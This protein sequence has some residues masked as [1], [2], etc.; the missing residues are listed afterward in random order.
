MERRLVALFVADAVGYSKRMGED[1]AATIAALSASRSIIDAEINGLGGRIFSTAGDS[2]VAEFSSSADAVNAALNIHAKL[3]QLAPTECFQFRIGIH[4]GDVRVSGD[5]LLGEGLNIAARL[6]PVAP[7]GGICITAT[8]HEQI[9]G[10]IDAGFLPSGR[11]RLKNISHPVE[12]W[13]W[14]ESAVRKRKTR[15]I[16]KLATLA[17]L[18]VCVFGGV[19]IIGWRNMAVVLD[20]PLPSGPKIAVVPF[21]EIGSPENEGFFADGLSRDVNALLS[22][23][24]NLFVLSPASMAQFRGAPDCEKIKDILDVDFILSGTVQRQADKLRVTTEFT[25]AKDCRQ[26]AAPGPFD[27]QLSAAGVLD[28]QLEIARKVVSQIGSS[29]API[30]DNTLIRRIELQAPD[31]LTAYECVLLSYWFYENFAPERHRKARTCLEN[32]VNED[33][34]YSLGWSRLAFSYLESKKYAIDTPPDWAERALEAAQKALS[35]N[36]ENPD[37]YYARAILSQM[38]REDRAVF[39]TN[40]ERAVLLNPND[41]FILA[42]LGTWMAYSGA[43]EKGKG[44]VQRAMLLNPMHQSWWYFIW[45]LHAYDQQQ[46]QASI[47]YSHKVDL[48]NNYMVQSVLTSAYA[49]NGNMQ[50]ARQTLEHVLKLK[51]EY[52]DDPRQPFNAR[53]MPAE[54]IEKL[55]DGLRMTGLEIP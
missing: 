41:S 6:E 10:R 39:R 47:D 23:F 44:W 29:D 49:M 25:D 14:P 15:K 43:W 8:V 13:S 11:L 28:V 38:K 16:A 21:V 2:V 46:Y 1:E 51:P 19:G 34:S 17:T 9:T 37:A 52:K 27:R 4:F 42:D 22:K 12:T 53:G 5:D 24:S 45:Q 7:H 31:K 40:A 35:L 36:E 33:A 48:P 32:A 26:L 20:D 30:F 50:R 55:M 18:V 54:L 3:A